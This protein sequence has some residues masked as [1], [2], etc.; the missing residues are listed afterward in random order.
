MCKAITGREY[1]KFVFTRD[2]SDALNVLT[3]WGARVG[4][5]RD[6]LS[7][8]DISL[9]LDT[10]TNPLLDDLD[11]ALLH[12]VETAKR[13]NEQARA[14][15]LGHLICSPDDI[16]VIPLHRSMAN[17]ITNKIV[18]SELVVLHLGTPATTELRNKIVCIEN[19]D[20]G[21]DWLFTKGIAGLMTQ[22]GGTNSH[23]AIRCS[24]FAIPAAIGCGEQLFSRLIKSKKLVLNCRDKK[25]ELLS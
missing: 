9:L 21:Y 22:Y 12:Y 19:A 16:F 18:E 6:D 4:L 5:S 15:K 14:L 25:V 2:L 17:F 3:Q 23:M 11:R 24:E 10:L 13:D 1:A 8:L 7:Y 20:P